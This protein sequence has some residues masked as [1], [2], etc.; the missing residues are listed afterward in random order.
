MNPRLAYRLT[1]YL[2]I[3]VG[4]GASIGIYRPHFMMYSI[5][6]SLLGFILSGINVYLNQKYFA[7]QDRFPKG[8]LGM[9]LSSLPVLF[10]LFM[11]FRSRH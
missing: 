7:E 2:S 10:L 11:I 5:A 1:G 3:A 8:L 4:I 9:F 6:L